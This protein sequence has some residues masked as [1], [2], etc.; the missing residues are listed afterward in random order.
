MGGNDKADKIDNL[1]AL[2]RYCHT[3]MG[4]T[5]THMEHLKKKHKEKLNG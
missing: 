4:D 3:V 1:M 5:K 2:C